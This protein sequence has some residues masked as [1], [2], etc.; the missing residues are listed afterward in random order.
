MTEVRMQLDSGFRR[1]DELEKVSMHI[2]C[3]NPGDHFAIRQIHQDAFG[4][5]V[6]ADLVEALRREE[7]SVI[8]LVAEEAGEILGHVMFSRMQAPFRALGLAPLAVRPAHQRKGIGSLL[9][10]TG[11]A[12]AR[13]DGWEGIFVLGEPVYYARFG[14]DPKQASGFQSLYAGSYLMAM[15]LQDSQLPCKNG[16]IDYA[17]AF[18]RFE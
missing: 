2:R 5:N 7:S 6:E 15:A 10:R 9:I 8:S 1:N 12:Q 14:F 13:A 3:E 16:R 17:P 18:A 11:L 4:Q